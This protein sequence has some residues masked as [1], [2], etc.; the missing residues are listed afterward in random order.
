M[1]H[2]REGG[3][4]PVAVYYDFGGGSGGLVV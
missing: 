1:F 2:L 3:S 4:K